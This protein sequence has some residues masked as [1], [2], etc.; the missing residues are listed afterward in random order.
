MV[1]WHSRSINEPNVV[2]QF[3]YKSAHLV[4]AMQECAF[5]NAIQFVSVLH[6]KHLQI[7]PTGQSLN[8]QY[9]CHVFSRQLDAHVKPSIFNEPLFLRG[10]INI[11][12]SLCLYL[13]CHRHIWTSLLL[14][15]HRAGSIRMGLNCLFPRECKVS[16]A[17]AQHRLL[18]EKCLHAPDFMHCNVIMYIFTDSYSASYLSLPQS[19][20][21][22][23]F[24]A[25]GSFN[26]ISTWS[27]NIKHVTGL[28][29]IK[30]VEC[31]CICWWSQS[32]SALFWN[33]S[34][35]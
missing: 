27:R 31:V 20:H 8:K 30:Y 11:S 21:R 35:L 22:V 6:K 3:Q 28:L 34:I 29:L 10:R 17:L 4:W 25:W 13:T 26:L 12:A 5:K 15:F 23:S 33:V 18:L 19:R 9:T 14:S 2:A 7:T 16:W 1:L 24:Y 32:L